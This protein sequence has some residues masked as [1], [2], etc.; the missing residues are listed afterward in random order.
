MEAITVDELIEV[1]KNISEQGYGSV[2][3]TAN[4]EYEVCGAGYDKR[5]N[6]VDIDCYC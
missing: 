3:V 4:L 6:V 1:L 5:L 2:K